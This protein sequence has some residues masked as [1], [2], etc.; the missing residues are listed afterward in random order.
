MLS[1]KITIN[2]LNPKQKPKTKTQN[3]NLKL[4]STNDLKLLKNL[5][6]VNGLTTNYLNTKDLISIE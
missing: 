4:V 3:K 5:L 1:S 2:T 6:I